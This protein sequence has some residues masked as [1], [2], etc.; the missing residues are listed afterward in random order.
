MR[1]EDKYI[2]LGF[3]G[4]CARDPEGVYK[5]GR[6]TLKRQELLKWKRLEDIEAT[7]IGFE[8]LLVNENPQELDAF[9]LTKRSS[10]KDNRLAVPL[11]GKLLVSSEQFGKFAVGSG[12]DHTMRTDIWRNKPKFL[13]KVVTV[14]YQA[15]GT[16]DKP[17]QPIFKGFRYD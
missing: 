2:N 15:H 1:L 13:N 12:F 7:I 3:E 10:C 9:G 5:N 16:K 6:A 11:L 14:K 8:P 17:R 4:I